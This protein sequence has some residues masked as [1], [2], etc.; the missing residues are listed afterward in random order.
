M[1]TVNRHGLALGVG[2]WVNVF[3]LLYTSLPIMHRF[4]SCHLRL[5]LDLSSNQSLHV[6]TY[7]VQLY[8]CS[9]DC[10]SANQILAFT[11]WNNNEK[12]KLWGFPLKCSN[13]K[14]W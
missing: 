11:I 7:S 14:Y 12:E 5:R 1:D 3:L 10:S 9:T 8:F 4:G 2:V 6:G 13:R